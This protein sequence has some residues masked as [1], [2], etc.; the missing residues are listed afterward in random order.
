MVTRAEAACFWPLRLWPEAWHRFAPPRGRGGLVFNGL[1]GL[2]FG[3]WGMAV[4]RVAG[5]FVG[6]DGEVVGVG[7]GEGGLEFLVGAGGA[8]EGDAV[9]D[10]FLDPLEVE[11]DHGGDEEGNEL[12]EEKAA[13]DD[14]A[15][16]APGFG[17]G[18]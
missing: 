3:G 18:A 14:E 2:G 10:V 7:G 16:G 4:G 12:G 8:E 15:E 9:E 6:C 13:D 17:I 5:V 1:L 11:V